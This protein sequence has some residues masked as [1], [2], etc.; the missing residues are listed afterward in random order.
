MNG[1]WYMLKNEDQFVY[2][3]TC[4]KTLAKKILPR[5]KL[6][7]SKFK[8]VN[9]PRES[10]DW[11]FIYFRQSSNSNFETQDLEKKLNH[12]IKHSWRVGCFCSDVSEAL[13]TREREDRGEDIFNSAHERGHSRPRMWAQYGGDYSGACLVFNKARLDAAI[14]EV[15]QVSKSDIYSDRVAYRNPSVVPKLDASNPYLISLDE[16]ER[17]GIK[18]V[19]ELHISRY[20]KHFFFLKARDWEQER[21]FRWIVRVDG[22]QEFFVPIESCLTGIALGDRFPNCFKGIVGRYAHAHGTSVV[23][24]EW[25]N[26]VPQPMPTHPSLLIN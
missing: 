20:W 19:V 9:D 10:K 17:V 22:D 2:H 11:A 25:K 13:V 12:L 26:G 7:F 4:S 5:G 18:Q 3:Y 1:I 21:E 23:N 16:I 6:R 8:N 24:I 15:P 14:K